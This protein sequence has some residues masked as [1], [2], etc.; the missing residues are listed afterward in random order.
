MGKKFRVEQN[1]KAFM[2]ELPDMPMTAAAP[3]EGEA[4]GI[5]I[6][7]TQD[8][9]QRAD[10]GFKSA[11]LA[12][13]G[14]MRAASFGLTDKIGLSPEGVKGQLL[15]KGVTPL[16]ANVVEGAGTLTGYAAM[17]PA[18]LEM[19]GGG[20]IL[21]SLLPAK[22]AQGAAS[23]GQKVAANVLGWGTTNAEESILRNMFGTDFN[24]GDMD[25]RMK[26]VLGNTTRDV[27]T[28]GAMEIGG[29][30]L[31]LGGKAA[32]NSP[33]AK[34]VVK[35][36][37]KLGVNAGEVFTNMVEHWKKT[38]SPIYQEVAK[39]AAT[40]GKTAEQL[41]EELSQQLM[42]EANRVKSSYEI[43]NKGRTWSGEVQFD[44]PSV[45]I[46]AP[47]LLSAEGNRSARLNEALNKPGYLRTAE[48]YSIIR[49]AQEVDKRPLMNP[50]ET[51]SNRPVIIN[52]PQVNAK[53]LI[54]PDW[55]KRK[56]EVEVTAP[57]PVQASVPAPAQPSAV[58]TPTQA[59]P[60]AGASAV[61]SP[62]TKIGS[63]PVQDTVTA[64]LD[65]RRREVNKWLRKNKLPVESKLDDQSKQLLQK[66]L[67]DN[68]IGSLRQYGEFIGQPIPLDKVKASPQSS[69]IENK[70]EPSLSALDKAKA[71]LK[72]EG[73]KLQ[74]KR[75]KEATPKM[76]SEGLTQ[77]AENLREKQQLLD[78]Q[79]QRGEPE[80]LIDITRGEL[81]VIKDAILN[82]VPKSNF[83]KTV[84]GKKFM[85][86]PQSLGELFNV[87]YV[88]E[89][90]VKLST[91]TTAQIAEIKT[92]LAKGQH[93][94]DPLGI[95]IR[96]WIGESP[97]GNSVGAMKIIN[98][99]F[100]LEQANQVRNAFKQTLG[101]LNTT[102][103]KFIEN[104]SV[105]FWLGQKNPEFKAVWNGV[106]DGILEGNEIYFRGLEGLE[107][108][109][110]HDLP[111]LSKDKIAKALWSGDSP[112]GRGFLNNSK[113]LT[114]N[115]I[116]KYYTD[117]E[118][119]S[120]YNFGPEEIKGYKNITGLM[121]YATSVEKEVR[122]HKYGYYD[123]PANDP[124]RSTMAQQIDE[125]VNKLFGYI[126]HGR[127]G[128]WAVTLPSTTANGKVR[129]FQLYKNEAEASK[130]LQNIANAYNVQV[131]DL[132]S[133]KRNDIVERFTNN[134][135]LENLSELFEATGYGASTKLK[136]ALALAEEAVRKEV[137]QRGFSQHFIK[138]NDVPGFDTSFEGALNSVHDY[139]LAST[140]RYSKTVGMKNARAAH[141]SMV[142]NGS[143]SPALEEVSKGWL[144]NLEDYGRPQLR[145][146]QKFL[147]SYYLGGKLSFFIQNLTQP[148][149][150]TRTEM[151]KYYKPFEIDKVFL[152]CYKEMFAYGASIKNGA[153]HAGNQ[154]YELL[155]KLHR[156]G[157]L[158]ASQ[159]SYLLAEHKALAS[160]RG[161]IS[162]GFEKAIKFFGQQSEQ[163][164][165]THAAI[166]AYK[167][168][169]KMNI[170]QSGLLTFVEE[171]INRTQYAFGR[172]NLPPAI[173]QAGNLEG[174]A[175]V[176]YQFKSF[177]H[178]MFHYMSDVM[179]TPSS[180]LLSYEN[181]RKI[182]LI[183]N[184]VG[185][186]G[187]TG[188]P[189]FSLVK[190]GFAQAGIDPEA[191]MRGVIKN[192][193]L[194][195]IMVRGLPTLAGADFS[196]LIGMG[197]VT[198]RGT[199]ITDL[200]GP[201]GG[202]LTKV[203]KAVEYMSMGEP[204]KAMEYASPGAL[205]AIMKAYRL[206][207]EGI[208]NKK[209]FM[210]DPNKLN[211]WETALQAGGIQ[212]IRVSE[213]YAKENA[214]YTLKAH[215]AQEVEDYNLKIAKYMVTKDYQSAQRMR[216]DAAKKGYKISMASVQENVRKLL[217]R[218]PKKKEAK[219]IRAR[220]ADIK[221]IY[222]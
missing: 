172:E 53:E 142:E 9:A 6:P 161:K 63:L 104:M 176:L 169:Q 29:S 137:M 76:Q 38:S 91:M 81:E 84:S 150:T 218:T 189:L 173:L 114:Q 126:P 185:G 110:L 26:K 201:V 35:G 215:R 216:M 133:G 209:D 74:V 28:M 10:I 30:L 69:I 178:N 125:Q 203:G 31:M 100:T 151:S 196:S 109:F 2:V 4:P 54:L 111:Q 190:W 43:A 123:I 135:N 3:N 66:H 73:D 105:P 124:R 79:I 182:S 198:P 107:E 155:D 199:D 51:P 64:Y 170:P 139:L 55:L 27:L 80:Y 103:I 207:K 46:N 143:V 47:E 117:A 25:M 127:K 45:V 92:A 148:F 212:P 16:E 17:L 188:L 210:L 159:I 1:G 12:T 128:T 180:R 202:T 39:V 32:I 162:L 121:D 140:F 181:H 93:P 72:Q 152:D 192:K 118:L 165:R 164:N 49:R 58:T 191:A 97:A 160:T 208:T 13:A 71:D 61:T 158:G 120:L 167:M 220:V 183:A 132:V 56:S 5:D 21:K 174:A 184:M 166:A 18:L 213:L 96:R 59:A 197:D 89:G 145:D 130:D 144:D 194:A 67:T 62:V 163:I 52:E 42:A 11:A 222:K 36:I 175:K 106:H 195:R 85:V 86:E 177:S 34:S 206:N 119:Q 193:T 153:S 138:R 136:Q 14:G 95:P 44:E 214:I 186:A 70:G 57:A 134:L 122:K 22:G 50:N 40:Q 33:L 82:Y 154:L 116:P 65:I 90:T 112:A 102:A 211:G 75:A 77:L 131:S 171:I 204:G 87:E 24:E 129:F 115:G 147:Y 60:T 98:F 41:A 179:R 68:N 221:R 200:S 15:Q 168:A 219:S 205:A 108:K 88:S 48:D 83:V 7:F 19:G 78:K 141:R 101:D 187:V 20:A 8:I 113:R 23:F 217:G 149:M 156:R 146:L 37:G 157:E 99:P 94:K